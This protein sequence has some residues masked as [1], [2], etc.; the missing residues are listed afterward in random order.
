M[1]FVGIEY[2]IKFQLGLLITIVLAIAS[3][4]GGCF[5]SASK[6]TTTQAFAGFSS[7]GS[8]R[9]QMPDFDLEGESPASR[10]ALIAAE[11]SVTFGTCLGIFFP[12]VTGI[13]G[14]IN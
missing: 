4:I 11:G 1:C 5:M 6:N 9:N 10:D 14:E 2:V 8:L 7:D 12:A 13:M 3:F